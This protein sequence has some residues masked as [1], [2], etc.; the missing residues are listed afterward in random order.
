MPAGT[1][2]RN[3][4]RSVKARWTVSEPRAYTNNREPVNCWHCFCKRLRW[5]RQEKCCKCG[6]VQDSH[7][8]FYYELP[9]DR[10]ELEGRDG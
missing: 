3:T 4:A 7:E 9:S 10:H 5:Q 6:L 8:C 2:R 1:R